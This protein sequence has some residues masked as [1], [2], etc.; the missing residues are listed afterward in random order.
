MIIWLSESRAVGQHKAP[1]YPVRVID[2]LLYTY[3][4]NFI[5]MPYLF[6][7]LDIVGVIT[8]DHC[9]IEL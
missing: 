5:H 2:T 1:N 6:N 7:R 4:S 3:H 9:C 8:I